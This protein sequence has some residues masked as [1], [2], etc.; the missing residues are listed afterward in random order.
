[1]SCLFSAT[2]AAASVQCR[3]HTSGLLTFPLALA[4]SVL[5]L[6]Y[7]CYRGVLQIE[8]I[9]WLSNQILSY[10]K[11]ALFFFNK[12]KSEAV[13]RG[14]FPTTLKELQLE[15]S[16]LTVQIYAS[17]LLWWA[18]LHLFLQGFYLVQKYG[19]IH[20]SCMVNTFF[21]SALT[22]HVSIN[23]STL[24]WIMTVH[25]HQTWQMACVLC[26]HEI[27]PNPYLKKR[28]T[29]QYKQF[30]GGIFS[31]LKSIGGKSAW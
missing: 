29:S 3:S 19:S 18:E 27:L 23:S 11:V 26:S 20:I 31:F 9:A 2:P 10:T 5:V 7:R 4:V 22:V 13:I 30:C 6:I 14:N 1:M 24:F 16:G 8:Q 25:L 17:T 28:W 12:T 21:F 15:Y